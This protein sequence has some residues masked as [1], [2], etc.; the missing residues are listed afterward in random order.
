MTTQ[1]PSVATIVEELR[2]YVGSQV[3]SPAIV[4]DAD[5]PLAQLGI[6]SSSLL[7]LLLFVERRF[8]VMVPDEELNRAN[9]SSLNA[10]AAC[11][12]RLVS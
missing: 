8:G 10:L 9:L 4:F 2:H 7:S 12:H 3:L 1:M 11:V 5:T 6:D